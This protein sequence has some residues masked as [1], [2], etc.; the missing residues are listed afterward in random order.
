M[1]CTRGSLVGGYIFDVTR[2]RAATGWRDLK[3]GMDNNPSD[4]VSHRY[5]VSVFGYYMFSMELHELTNITQNGRM[6]SE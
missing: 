1:R 3:W 4:H 6:K 5:R 2:R